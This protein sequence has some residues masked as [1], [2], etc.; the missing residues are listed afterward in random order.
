VIKKPCGRGNHSP[1]WAAEP[2]NIIII[3]III[4][5]I[6]LSVIGDF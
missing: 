2:E 5:Q 6:N 1:P 4:H 3:I